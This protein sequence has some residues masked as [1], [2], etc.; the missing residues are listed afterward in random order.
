MSLATLRTPVLALLIGMF[1]A[2]CGDAPVPLA[3]TGSV[4]DLATF[5]VVARTEPVTQSWDGVVE[6]TKQVILTAQTNARVEAL[7]HEVGDVVAAGDV[8]VRF[9]DVEQQ[10]ARDAAA[11]MIAAARAER[12][13]MEAEYERIR[14]IHERG[15]ASAAELDRAL[16][17]RD[18]ARAAL[19]S[20]QAQARQADR[21]LDYTVVRA[22]YAG[23][24]TRRFVEVGEAVQ[25][26]PPSPQK[27]IA[28]ESLEQLRVEVEVP[29]GV[30]G[31]IRASGQA[32]L[33]PDSGARLAVQQVIVHPRADPASHSFGVRL[34]LE[35]APAGLYPGMTVKVH[36]AVAE[37]ERIRVPASA[38][39]QQGE[40]AGVYLVEG[41]TVA[42]RQVRIGDRADGL[43]EILAGLADGDVVASDPVAAM[44]W[45]VAQRAGTGT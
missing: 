11:A 38:L 26:G 30:A 40:L 12:L 6:A 19:T 20:L 5:T 42:L 43:A 34:E 45:L 15:L 27:L 7:P 39:W 29:Q 21:Q 32:W 22:P 16:A 41:P 25:A 9:S 10:S 36:F 17:A 4:P 3:G 28:I 23:I 35:Q 33:E 1:V 24:V 14:S 8:L 2:A 44:Q 13:N 18:A 31:P 37:V